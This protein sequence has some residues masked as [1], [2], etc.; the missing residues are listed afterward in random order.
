MTQSFNLIDQ[1]W[2]PCETLDGKLVELGLR[3]A[4]ADAHMLRGISADNPL[5]TAALYRLLLAVLHRVFGPSGTAEWFDL[6]RG[7]QWDGARLDAY[8]ETWYDRFDL[9]HPDE[10]RR[11]YQRVP[12]DGK[13]TPIIH[14]VQSGGNNPAL[15]SHITDASEP[16]MTLAQAARAVVTAQAFRLG[17]IIKPPISGTDSPAARGIS[18]L[19]EGRSLF[20]TTIFNLWTY[21]D[22][23]FS[24]ITGI[25]QTE[26]DAPA[27]EQGDPF[28]PERSLP[29]GYLDYLTWQSYRLWLEEP[30]HGLI[31]EAQ[32]GLGQ[33][34]LANTVLDPFKHHRAMKK[35]SQNSPGYTPLRFN[36]NRAL[37]RD[38]ATILERAQP[39]EGQADRHPYCITWLDALFAEDYDNTLSGY[40]RLPLMALG[41]ASDQA[42]VDFYRQERMPIPAAYLRDRQLVSLLRDGLG[43]AEE[44]RQALSKALYLLAKLMIAPNVGEEGGRDPRPEDIRPLVAHWNVERQYWGAVEPAFWQLVADLPLDSTAALVTWV[45]I[46]IQAARESYASAETIAG[47]E[48]RALKAAAA[49]RRSLEWNLAAMRKEIE[50]WQTV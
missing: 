32:I 50:Q 27:W 34:K 3:D 31:R 44:A 29:L 26:R 35:S 45:G 19:L 33:P 14:L 36:E 16:G 10:D 7:G 8:W 17:G 40:E 23:I 5:E 47:S 46:L 13:S 39:W 30:S 11:F 41:M 42:K 6:W 21:A 48:T 15:F 18:F 49:G 22:T 28:Q 37:W 12:V 1:L 9:L 2:I 4:L 20:E 38:S 43:K 24:Q 25:P